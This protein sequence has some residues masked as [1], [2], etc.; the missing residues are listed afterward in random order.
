MSIGG[1]SIV[2]DGEDSSDMKEV[3]PQ[4]NFSEKKTYSVQ[5]LSEPLPIKQLSDLLQSI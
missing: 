4:K 2:I 1:G 3:Y 5:V